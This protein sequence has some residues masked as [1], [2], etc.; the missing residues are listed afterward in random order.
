LFYGLIPVDDDEPLS[1]DTMGY[2]TRETK[3]NGA[4]LNIPATGEATTDVIVDKQTFCHLGMW[5]DFNDRRTLRCEALEKCTRQ[6][7]QRCTL[8]KPFMGKALRGYGEC[9]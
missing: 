7:Y 3:S 6:C 4:L 1:S 5:P 8:F 2:P 9:T